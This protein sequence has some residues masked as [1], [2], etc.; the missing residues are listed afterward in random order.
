MKDLKE[1]INL[2]GYGQKDPLIEY[3][4]E[5]FSMFVELMDLISNEVVELVFKLYPER[6]EQ[7]PPLRQRRPMKREQLVYRHD[8]VAAAAFAPH[9]ETV[10]APQAQHSQEQR[11]QTIRVPQKIGRNEPCPCG[12]G[13]KYKNCHG[14]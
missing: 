11:V 2:S 4:T 8:A 13:K 3:K 14:A 7:L 9:P 6:P 10:G 5:A 12:S 1:G